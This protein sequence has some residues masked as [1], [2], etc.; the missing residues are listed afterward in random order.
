MLRRLTEAAAYLRPKTIA[1]IASRLARLTADHDALSR[2]TRE[3]TRALESRLR[4][5][6][7]EAARDRKLTA[8]SAADHAAQLT[9][10]TAQVTALEGT[11]RRLE[12]RNH[13]LTI[14]MERVTNDD[15]RTR[16]VADVLDTAAVRAHVQAVVDRT[17]LEL[18]PYP[19]MVLDGLL[20]QTFYDVLMDTMPPRGLF[21]D[22]VNKDQ[23]R[24]PPREAGVATYRIWKFLVAEILE[25]Q[26]QDALLTRFREPLT[27]YARRFWPSA[28]LDELRLNGSD[29]RIILRQRGY[30]IPPHRDPKW[31]WLTFILYLAKPGDPDTWGTQLYRVSDDVE[32][33][34]AKPYWMESHDNVLARDVR[35]LPNRALVFL[36]ADGSHGASI[37][38]DAPADFERYIYQFRVGP[39]RQTIERLKQQL[40]PEARARWE[41]K[42][43]Y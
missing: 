10:L 18:D 43:G 35:F 13:H 21:D 24:V 4:D 32:A 16:L 1:K 30:V 22:A 41:G 14:A 17:P 8:G 23:L 19:H 28:T 3:Q 33:P 12:T 37:P 9:A 36:N 42:K 29:G 40:T 26:L 5:V 25:G 31:A 39:E 2:S 6:S 7:R 34:G 38:E 15:E 11:V 20:P 27:E